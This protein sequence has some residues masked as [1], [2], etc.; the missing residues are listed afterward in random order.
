MLYEKD[1]RIIHHIHIPKCGG[2]SIRALL[3][4]NGWNITEN[5]IPPQLQNEVCGFDKT[6]HAHRNV[7]MSWGANPEFQFATVRNPYSKFDSKMRQIANEAIR[8]SG[9]DMSKYEGMTLA[10]EVKSVRISLIKKVVDFGDLNNHFRRQVDF[11]GPETFV[12]KLED[13]M[14][15]V[16]ED[17]VNR[18]IISADSKIK[19]LNAKKYLDVKVPWELPEYQELH[20]VFK[21]IYQQDFKLFEYEMRN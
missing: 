9:G 14:Q 3:R 10:P 5:R 17:L 8:D 7:W 21:N 13:G 6:H 2:T 18:E 12:Y 4:E 19:K 15:P 20:E 1:G 16:L 11:L